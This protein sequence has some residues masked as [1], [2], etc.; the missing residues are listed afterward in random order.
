MT[1]QGRCLGRGTAVPSGAAVAAG[2]YL[3]LRSANGGRWLD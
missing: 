1:D 3:W 2:L